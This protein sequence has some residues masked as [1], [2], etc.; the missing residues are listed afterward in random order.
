MRRGQD[1]DLWLRLAHAGARIDD[2]RDAL[3]ERVVLADGLSPDPVTELERAIRVLN[4]VRAK[5]TLDAGD[6]ELLQQRITFLASALELERGKRGLRMGR[7]DVARRHF[8]R[9]IALTPRW[10]LRVS[11]SR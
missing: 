9:S 8:Q 4:G 6:C 1:C 11:S 2:Q 5:L 7:F 3:I 10:K